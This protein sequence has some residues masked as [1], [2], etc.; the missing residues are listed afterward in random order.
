[1]GLSEISK[2]LCP[3]KSPFYIS[4]RLFMGT[5]LSQLIGLST[6]SPSC[7]G[8][9]FI[10]IIING[11]PSIVFQFLIFFSFFVFWFFETGFPCVALAVL[12][13]AL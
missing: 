11:Y 1:M 3:F 8:F 4:I 12:E 5:V 7:P 9:F 6:L 13:L 10:I 2:A